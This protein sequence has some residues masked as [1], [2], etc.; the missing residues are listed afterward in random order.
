M[1]GDIVLLRYLWYLLADLSEMIYTVAG[2]SFSLQ[3]SL[4][5]KHEY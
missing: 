4:L 1:E 3:V 2:M 5:L